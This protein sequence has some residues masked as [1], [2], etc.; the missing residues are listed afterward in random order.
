MSVIAFSFTATV[1]AVETAPNLRQAHRPG[2]RLTVGLTYGKLANPL[3]AGTHD[4]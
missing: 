1:T 2:H 3:D 4:W